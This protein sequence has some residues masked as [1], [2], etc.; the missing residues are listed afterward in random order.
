MLHARTVEA[1]AT[2]E[3]NHWHVQ[4]LLE[5][6]ATNGALLA[7]QSWVLRHEGLQGNAQRRVTLLHGHSTAPDETLFLKTSV[8]LPASAKPIEDDLVGTD[9]YVDIYTVFTLKE[10]GLD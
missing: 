2:V 8:D 9:T 7:G 4:R 6:V 3:V 10:G 1:V 5:L